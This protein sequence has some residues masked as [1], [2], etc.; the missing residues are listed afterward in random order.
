MHR[1]KIGDQYVSDL[2][3]EEKHTAVAFGSG[4]LYVFSTPMM[5]GLME[6]AAMICAQNSL[7]PAYS[8]VGIAVAIEH[9]AATPMGQKVKAVATVTEVEGKKITFEVEAYDEVECIGR[10]KHTRFI[11]EAESFLK[12]VNDKGSKG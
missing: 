6:N 12:R 1:I 3:V 11:V 10:G 4:N 8:S 9:L 2:L 7:D 5:I